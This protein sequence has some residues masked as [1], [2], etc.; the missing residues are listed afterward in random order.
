LPFFAEE[1]NL[2][3]KR[4]EKRMQNACVLLLAQAPPAFST[5]AL[6]SVFW[7]VLPLLEHLTSAA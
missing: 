6:Q 5:A 3:E 7:D 4:N 2:W 1:K